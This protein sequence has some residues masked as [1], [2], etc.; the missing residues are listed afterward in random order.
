MIHPA[1]GWVKCVWVK[2]VW[3]NWRQHELSI[4]RAGR[5]PRNACRLGQI[6]GK[7]RACNAREA[8]VDRLGNAGAGMLMAVASVKHRRRRH[9]MYARM[10]TIQTQPGTIDEAI[11]IAQ[12]AVL[13]AAR[14]QP[15]F[16]GVL[17]L[18]DY[19]TGK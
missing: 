16:K 15:G 7:L 19:S 2:C 14:Q 18:V 12:D 10:T 5:E 6:A 1:G 8:P 11:R 13:P 3:P 17:A 9:T 4:A